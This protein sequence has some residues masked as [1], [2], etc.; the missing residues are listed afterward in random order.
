[1]LWWFQMVS[2][3]VHCLLSIHLWKHRITNACSESVG[4]GEFCFHGCSFNR[5]E[6]KISTKYLELEQ[7]SIS[8]IPFHGSAFIRIIIYLLFFLFFILTLLSML[9][10]A[11]ELLLTT[12]RKKNCFIREKKGKLGRIQSAWHMLSLLRLS[13]LKCLWDF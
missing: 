11:L 8:N 3:L 9:W 1:M 12:C 4:T 7:I 5:K 6:R 10:I 2:M 13:V